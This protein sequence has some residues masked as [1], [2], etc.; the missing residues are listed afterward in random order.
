MHELHKTQVRG[1]EMDFV[2]IILVGFAAFGIGV[3]IGSL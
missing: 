2:T 3:I 1:I